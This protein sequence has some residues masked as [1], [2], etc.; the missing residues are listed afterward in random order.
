MSLLEC[1][2]LRPRQKHKSNNMWT[3][4]RN[5]KLGS[6]IKRLYGKFARVYLNLKTLMKCYAPLQKKQLKNLMNNFNQ[7]MLKSVFSL[8]ILI[9]VLR[10]NTEKLGYHSF[11]NTQG[12]LVKTSNIPYLEAAFAKIKSCFSKEKGA[13]YKLCWLSLNI[14]LSMMTLR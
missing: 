12:F 6:V 11:R 1:R 4:Q 8:K 5:K 13:D 2:T 3:F 7:H 14:S 10:Q 9:K